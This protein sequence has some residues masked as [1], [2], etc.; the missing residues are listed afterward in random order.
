MSPLEKLFAVLDVVHKPDEPQQGWLLL[1]LALGKKAGLKPR[2]EGK[3]DQIEAIHLYV[4][5]STAEHRYRIEE[6][7]RDGL[8]LAVPTLSG[9][10]PRMGELLQAEEYAR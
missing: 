8:G 4:P 3:D 1:L 6:H 9:R 2:F 7:R 5:G 10:T